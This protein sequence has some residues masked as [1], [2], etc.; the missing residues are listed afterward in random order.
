LKKC[1]KHLPLYRETDHRRGN[2][3]RDIDLIKL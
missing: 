1:F 3:Q 2:F